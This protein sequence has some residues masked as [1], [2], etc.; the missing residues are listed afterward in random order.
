MPEDPHGLDPAGGLQEDIAAGPNLG[1]GATGS[2]VESTSSYD[3]GGGFKMEVIEYGDN[4]Q[5]IQYGPDGNVLSNTVYLDDVVVPVDD[6][7][8]PAGGDDGG[9]GFHQTSVE[10]ELKK[11][12]GGESPLAIDLETGKRKG[13]TPKPISPEDMAR[14]D[15]TID[16]VTGESRPKPKPNENVGPGATASDDDGEGTGPSGDT[17]GVGGP[18][19]EGKGF[20]SKGKKENERTARDAVIQPEGPNDGEGTVEN[21]FESH[22]GESPFRK[23]PILVGDPSVGQ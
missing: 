1:S 14:Q 3:M 7:G 18:L 9:R 5:I 13:R 12:F 8:Q 17:P 20:G 11:K 16:P 22:E 15:L 10:I 6:P 4:I 23:L 2:A 21:R 19:G